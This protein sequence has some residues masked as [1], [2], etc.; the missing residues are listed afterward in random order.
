MTRLSLFL[1]ALVVAGCAPAFETTIAWTIDGEDPAVVCPTLP[2]G[3]TV[4]LD[5]V[6]RDAGGGDDVITHVAAECGRGSTIVTSGPFAEV[7]MSLVDGDTI[8]AVS[9]PIALDPG[10]P[11]AG[12]RRDHAPVVVDL[13]V[14]SGTLRA[15]LTVGG[16]SCAEAGASSFSVSL[17]QYAESRTLVPVVTDVDVACD[18]DVAVFTHAPVD[19][20]ATYS[21]TAS[22]TVDNVVWSTGEAG[23]AVLIDGANTSVDVSLDPAGGS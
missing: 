3:T 17:R 8:L 1:L 15:T 13:R 2:E 5:T 14:V 19:V 7:T 6:S 12:T 4:E 22:T 18:D 10:A 23:H 20:G 9:A 16:R 21:L 11:A